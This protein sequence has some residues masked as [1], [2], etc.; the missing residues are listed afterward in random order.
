MRLRSLPHFRALFLL[1][2][3]AVPALI[4]VQEA[5]GDGYDMT[6][7][8]IGEEPTQQQSNGGGWLSEI[9]IG[10][11]AHDVDAVSFNRENGNDFNGE[12]IFDSPD[13]QIFRDIYAPRLRFGTTINDSDNTSHVYGGLLWDTEIWNG[14]GFFEFGLGGAVHDGETY[15]YERDRK[16][17]GSRVLFHLSAG[18]GINVTP[19]NNISLY[20]EHISNGYLADPNEGM[21]NVGIR[22]GLRF[23]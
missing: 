20:L 12:L 13:N 11:F 19:S 9:R 7:E 3:I 21:D 16:S 14:S 8:H 10:Y 6:G 2:A 1:L 4:S 22:Y 18:I 23:D 17:L 5:R 15:T